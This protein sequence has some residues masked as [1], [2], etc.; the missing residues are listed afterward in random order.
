MPDQLKRRAS[1]ISTMSQF[2]QQAEEKVK[3]CKKCHVKYS[4]IWWPMDHMHDLEEL[5]LLCQ[6]CHWGIVHGNAVVN[7]DS[8]GTENP[9]ANEIDGVQGTRMGISVS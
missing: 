5:R 3:Q 9:L 4:P 2:L 8:D 1:E 7:G 6:K